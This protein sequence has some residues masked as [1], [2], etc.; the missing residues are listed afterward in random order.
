MYYQLQ[1]HFKI[2][3]LMTDSSI[4][5]FTFSLADSLDFFGSFSSTSNSS[6]SSSRSIGPG[7]SACLRFSKIATVF[8]L[9]AIVFFSLLGFVSAA[10]EFLSMSSSRKKARCRRFGGSL[11]ETAKNP[12]LKEIWRYFGS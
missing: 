8:G 1:M 9:G 12:N 10:S 6:E 4:I 2:S 7:E 3:C 5:I 11:M